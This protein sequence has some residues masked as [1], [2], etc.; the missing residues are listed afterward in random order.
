M[1]ATIHGVV[2]RTFRCTSAPPAHAPAAAQA[3][4]RVVLKQ[5]FSSP[6]RVHAVVDCGMGAAG[7]QAATLMRKRLAAGQPCTAH[8]KW[9][10]PIGGSMDLLLRGCAE[11]F[12]EEPA[13]QAVREAA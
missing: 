2:E 9:L 6:V 5:S 11:I 12:T 13:C 8:G 1:T 7:E 10:E 4:V 3:Q